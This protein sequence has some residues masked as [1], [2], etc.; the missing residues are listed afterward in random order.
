[1]SRYAS[2]GGGPVAA[3]LEFKK[4]VKA[5]H[6]AGIEDNGQASID[7][8]LSALMLWSDFE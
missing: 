1:M 2:S 7:E 3:S 8:M 6:Q 5:L 4:M